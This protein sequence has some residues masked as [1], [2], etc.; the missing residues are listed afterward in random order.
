MKERQE[1]NISKKIVL[2]RLHH[3]M[4]NEILQK[5]NKKKRKFIKQ[6]KKNNKRGITGALKRAARKRK[7]QIRKNLGDLKR[8]KPNTYKFIKNEKMNIKKKERQVKKIKKIKQFKKIQE[9]NRPS[10]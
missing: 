6:V 10:K 8:S 2:H 3:Q 4:R 5:M 9:W 1:T 7:Q